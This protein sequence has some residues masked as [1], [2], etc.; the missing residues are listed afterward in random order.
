M[1]SSP[2]TK[3]ILITRL[4]IFGGEGL[5]HLFQR[6][7]QVQT[8]GKLAGSEPAQKSPAG[9]SWSATHLRPQHDSLDAPKLPWVC[10]RM[11]PACSHRPG[12]S[13]LGIP[14]SIQVPVI[15]IIHTNL[16]HLCTPPLQLQWWVGPRHEK[17]LP[18]SNNGTSSA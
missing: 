10:V 12:P 5:P 11:C 4:T 14:S 6:V 16:F 9:G 7:A 15:P 3:Q 13:R 2:R 18:L 8:L 17:E 1:V